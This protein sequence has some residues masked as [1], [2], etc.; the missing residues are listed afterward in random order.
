M[1]VLDDLISECYRLLVN[2]DVLGDLSAVEHLSGTSASFVYCPLLSVKSQP[3]TKEPE[4]EQK[5]LSLHL[6]PN[7]HMF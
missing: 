3:Q 1:L 5:Y 6:T 2:Q 4:F 7:F